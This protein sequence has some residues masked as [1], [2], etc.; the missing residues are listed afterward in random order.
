MSKYQ[1]KYCLKGLRNLKCAEFMQ[2]VPDYWKYRNPSS[3]IF[4]CL[5]IREKKMQISE[6]ENLSE[7]Q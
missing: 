2:P 4:V 6:K 1:L 7:T 3:K 5:N